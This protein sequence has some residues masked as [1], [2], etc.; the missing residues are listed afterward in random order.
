MEPFNPFRFIG[1]IMFLAIAGIILTFAF[2]AYLVV[3][4]TKTGKP[5]Y[6]CYAFVARPLGVIAE[7]GK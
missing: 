3:D 7:E 2:N 5:L 6:Q 4:C 1:V